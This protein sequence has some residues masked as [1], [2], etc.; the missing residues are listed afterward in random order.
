MPKLSPNLTPMVTINL[1][2]V[3]TKL[4]NTRMTYAT[5]KQYRMNSENQQT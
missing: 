5:T 2:Y 4:N 1:F 3:K